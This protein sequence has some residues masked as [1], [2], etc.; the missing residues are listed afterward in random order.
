MATVPFQ[1]APVNRAHVLGRVF[2]Q[3][4]GLAGILAGSAMLFTLWLIPLG[5]PLLL[6]GLALVSDAG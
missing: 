1:H 3:S 4:A 2:Q 6:L 5:L